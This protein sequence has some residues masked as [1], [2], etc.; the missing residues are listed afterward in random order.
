MV[1]LSLTGVNIHTSHLCSSPVKELQE[2]WKEE[3][4]HKEFTNEI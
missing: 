3:P 4:T 2:A 1:S